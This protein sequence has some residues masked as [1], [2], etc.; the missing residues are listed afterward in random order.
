[1]LLKG[2]SALRARGAR[3]AF[4]AWEEAAGLTALGM[5]RARAALCEWSGAS[6]R[7]AYRSWSEAQTTRRRLRAA[8][9]SGALLPGA[10]AGGSGAT[11]GQ[12]ACDELSFVSDIQFGT[13]DTYVLPLHRTVRLESNPSQ[14]H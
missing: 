3:R 7:R 10:G 9:K 2:A 8:A 5:R 1:M 12:G 11:E 4:T 14:H 13:G 6:V